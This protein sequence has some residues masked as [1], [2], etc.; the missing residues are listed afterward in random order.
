MEREV[1]KIGGRKARGSEWLRSGNSC[2][3]PEKASRKPWRSSWES[4]LVQESGENWGLET[5][6][7]ESWEHRCHLETGNCWNCSGRV[8]RDEGLGKNQYLEDGGWRGEGP[9]HVIQRLRRN[10]QGSGK[11]RKRGDKYGSQK[12]LEQKCSQVRWEASIHLGKQKGKETRNV[13]KTQVL[14]YQEWLVKSTDLDL[15]GP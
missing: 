2:K 13:R 8:F 4:S 14:E 5:V 3:L 12:S 6:I 7:W 1:D 15:T 9:G 11:E 10:G